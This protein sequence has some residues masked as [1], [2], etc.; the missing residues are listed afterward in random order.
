THFIFR[1]IG[2]GKITVN[3]FDPEWADPTYKIARFLIIAFAL[4]L[5][6]PYLP[7]SGSPAFQQISIFL[8]VLISLGSTGAVSN[9]IAG[10]F[11]TYTGAFRIGDRVRIAD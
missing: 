1:E 5:I 3:E 2:R 11:L 10:V 8:G 4:V 6:F 9:I 7:G